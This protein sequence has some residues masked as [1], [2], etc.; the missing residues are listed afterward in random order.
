MLFRSF[1]CYIK[2]IPLKE[3]AIEHI[4]SSIAQL[5]QLPVP[6]TLIVLVDHEAIDTIP[7]GTQ[8]IAFASVDLEYPSFKRSFIDWSK[9]LNYLMSFREITEVSAFDEWIVNIDRNLGNILYDGGNR[10]FFID[11]GLALGNISNCQLLSPVNKIIDLAKSVLQQ[12]ELE[13]KYYYIE[14]KFIPRITRAIVDNIV[15]DDYYRFGLLNKDDISFIRNYL[16]ER[17]PFLVPLL[18]AKYGVRQMELD[19]E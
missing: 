1:T 11:H 17:I 19:Y 9:Y 4:C 16:D 18:M 6:D 15:S 2:L 14:E 13:E 7:E 8:Q 3:V 5:V 12:D 10:L